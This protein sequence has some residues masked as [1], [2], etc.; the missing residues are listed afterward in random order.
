MIKMSFTTVNED[1]VIFRRIQDENRPPLITIEKTKRFRKEKVF[2]L[3]DDKLR[4]LKS[5]R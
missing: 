1:V 4:I 3:D 5:M 2:K